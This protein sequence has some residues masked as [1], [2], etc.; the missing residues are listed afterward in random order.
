MDFS[1]WRN[2]PLV[3]LHA[4]HRSHV[5]LELSG[6]HLGCADSSHDVYQGCLIQPAD[7]DS[8]PVFDLVTSTDIAQC[9]GDACKAAARAVVEYHKLLGVIT[10]MRWD[11]VQVTQ[12][13]SGV[14]PVMNQTT[15][16]WQRSCIALEG[17]VDNAAF[18]HEQLDGVQARMSA[19]APQLA[20]SCVAPAR[21]PDIIPFAIFPPPMKDGEGKPPADAEPPIS[22][23]APGA[24]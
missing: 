7:T 24:A 4:S 19:A 23:L 5:S 16:T 14:A 21:H 12:G 18:V 13:Y 20:A 11:T 2:V 15:W 9:A 3:L 1:G 10:K 17:I 22:M 8:N 6:P